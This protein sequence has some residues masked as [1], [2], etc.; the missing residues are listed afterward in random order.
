M[1]RVITSPAVEIAMRTLDD[2][3]RRRVHAW[4]DHLK[5]WDTDPAVQKASMALEGQPNLY[6]LLTTTEIRI[7]F[8]IEQQTITVLDVANQAA[9][10]ASGSRAAVH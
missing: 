6:M 10:A 7:F 8:R 2:D 4:L 9:I 5:R 3:G 1:M